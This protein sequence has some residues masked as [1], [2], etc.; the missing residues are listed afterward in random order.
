[1]LS[2]TV[3]ILLLVATVVTLIFQGVPLYLAA[4][5]PR[6]DPGD[7][8]AVAHRPR[9]SVVIAARNEATDIGPCLDDL[10]A[11][12]YP[13]LEIVVVDGRSTDGTAD[14]ARSRGARVRVVDEPPLPFGWVGKNWACHWG[15]VYATGDF[16]LFV[17]ADVRA[18]PDAVRATIA[19]AITDGAD[20]TTLAPRIEMTS[21]W[22]KV[23]LPF[24]TQVV[25]TYF[26]APRV[27]RPGSRA[28][29]A[30]GQ[31]FLIRR[32][33]YDTIGG[34]AA[35]RGFVLEDVALAQRLRAQGRRLRVGWAPDLLSTRMYRDRQEMFEGL[36]KNIH[37][38]RFRAS[39]QLA[40][41]ALL[42]GFYW[43]PFAILPL[44][45]FTNSLVVVGAGAVLWVAL[46]GKHAGFAH[47][48]R[49]SA[50]H[51]LL[52][53]LAVGFYV[54]LVGVSIVRGL[55][56]APVVW[57]GRQYSLDPPREAT[58]R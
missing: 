42:I 35:V 52:F 51:G 15:S 7:R 21:F 38:T 12:T 54:A 58:K 10:L 27:N 9:V 23:V 33:A 16:L 53:P 24:Y 44:G 1:M 19:W 45:W 22:E 49:G 36:L 6:V 30:N 17:D 31:F 41:L 37:G 48:T 57:K 5:M 3:V 55:R 25:L 32:E 50:R 34:H 20:L 18:H 8:P 4:E 56:R 46:F 2:A 28:A 14:V 26:R 43:L 11:Q 40:F 47:A 13:D 29:M 39:R